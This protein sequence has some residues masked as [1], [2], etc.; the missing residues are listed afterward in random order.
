MNGG[1]LE[2]I[3][4]LSPGV[5]GR[6]RPP[7]PRISTGR[8][9]FPTQP[10]SARIVSHESVRTRYVVKNGRITRSSSALRQRPPRNAIAYAS[11]YPITSDRRVA[12][13]AY[14][15]ERTNWSEYV[16]STSAYV[17]K[18]QV[19]GYPVSIEPSFRE[20]AAR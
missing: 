16:E 1:K 20:S 18:C 17:W 7:G 5:V 11:G 13:P 8:G 2:G 4:A 9:G 15:N 10:S 14:P 3:P 12:A 19:K 6:T